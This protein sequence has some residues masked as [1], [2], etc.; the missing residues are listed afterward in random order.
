MIGNAQVK[1]GIMKDKTITI[2]A[3]TS[4]ISPTTLIFLNKYPRNNNNPISMR[5]AK[6]NDSDSPTII[7]KIRGTI[8]ARP[9]KY[10]IVLK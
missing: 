5:R 10:N 4:P 7:E 9:R 3:S 8:C 6:I 2:Y 1:A